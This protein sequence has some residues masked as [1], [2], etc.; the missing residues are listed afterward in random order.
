MNIWQGIIIG[1]LFA[2]SV[3]AATTPASMDQD[4]AYQLV[5]SLTVEVGPRIAGSE[6]D[7]RAV[8]WALNKFTQLGYDKVWTEE[9][10]MP[11]WT[12]G[13][14][15]LEVVSPFAQPFVLTSLGG[16]VGTPK[17]GIRASVVMFDSIEAL[18]KADAAAVK[19]KIVFINKPMTKDKSGSFYGQVVAARS[20]GAVEAAKLGAVAIVIRSVGTSNNRFAHTGTMKYDETIAKIPA[21]AISVPDA[22]N[23]AKMLERS[24]RVELKLQM[25]NQL[26]KATSHNVIAE[27]T[28]T[29]KPEE[30][31]LISGHLDSWDQGT[32]ALDDGAG[33]AL[34]MATGALIKQKIKPKRTIRVV[35]YGNE[36]GGLLGAR[37]YAAKHHKD[38]DKHVLAAESDFGAGRIWQIE[39]RFGD[40]ALPFAKELQQKLA[41]LDIALGGNSTYGGPDVS[42]LAQAGVPVVALSQDGTD[43]FDYHHTP[44]DTL[45]KIDPDSLK[46]NLQAWLIMTET[47]ANSSVNL[48][49]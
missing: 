44:N 20:R 43:Y 16:S 35:L 30:I 40:K 11:G 12:R 3:W 42:V 13:Q 37:A 47:V 24:S 23:L 17:A 14:A 7:R 5:E 15:S 18:E 32:G 38:L 22:Q 41:H 19:G 1:A 34:V 26:E 48:R 49:H 21:V 4:L 10:D 8:Q 2:P 9:F 25:E 29:E 36:E 46:Q 45:D 27:I 31:V 39:S 28:G 33:V 6:A